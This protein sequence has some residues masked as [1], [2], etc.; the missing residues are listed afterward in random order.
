MAKIRPA[1]FA[2]VASILAACATPTQQYWAF[3][4][5]YKASPQPKAMYYAEGFQDEWTVGAASS[6]YVGSNEEARNVVKRACANA[7]RKNRLNHLECKPQYL[8]SEYVYS[9]VSH[10]QTIELAHLRSRSNSLLQPN[11]QNRLPPRRPFIGKRDV[12][13]LPKRSSLH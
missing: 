13:T 6:P 4:Q 12:T 1:L 2:T 9:R 11:S 10:W 8:T 3:Q 5:Q 7:L